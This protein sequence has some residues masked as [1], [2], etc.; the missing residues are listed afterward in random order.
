MDQ[1]LRNLKEKKSEKTLEELKNFIE[2]N[3]IENYIN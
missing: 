3:P 1:I 2:E